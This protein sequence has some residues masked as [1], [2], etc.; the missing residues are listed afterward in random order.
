[1]ST[2][3]EYVIERSFNA[4][5]NLVWRTFTDPELLSRWYGPGVE[6]VIYT[7]DLRPCGEWRNGMGRN[8]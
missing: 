7:F 3:A 1:M 4:P 8:V 5:I 2:T 6:T